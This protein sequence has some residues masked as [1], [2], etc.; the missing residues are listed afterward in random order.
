MM[1]SSD[2]LAP[3]AQFLKLMKWTLGAALGAVLLS[4]LYLAARN[5][6]HSIHMF[7]AAALGAGCAVLLAGMLMGLIFLSDRSGL[8]DRAGK[9][10]ERDPMDADKDPSR[11]H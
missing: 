7:V 9:G 5:G 2:R 1:P 10:V 6:P 11:R 4:I 3:R 8:D